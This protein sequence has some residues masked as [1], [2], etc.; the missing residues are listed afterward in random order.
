M[1]CLAIPGR[2]LSVEGATGMVDMNGIEVRVGL[3]LVPGAK[4]GDYV[5]MHAGFAIQIIDEDEAR[6]TAELLAEYVYP[7]EDV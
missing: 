5:L 7:E 1:M 6:E 2:I 4:T 3:Q